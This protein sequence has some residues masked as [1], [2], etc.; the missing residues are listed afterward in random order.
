VLAAEI[1]GGLE[2]EDPQRAAFLS[3]LYSQEDPRVRQAVLRATS[4]VAELTVDRLV[5]RA[6]RSD[7]TGVLAAACDALEE[8]APGWRAAPPPP[9]TP[10]LSVRTPGAPMPAAPPPPVTAPAER[11]VQRA[12]A[13]AL[14]TLQAAD[15]LEALQA[16]ASAVAA[17]G[18][19]G[20]ED[21]LRQ[22]AAHTNPAVRT[23]ARETLSSLS[24]SMTDLPAPAHPVNPLEVDQLRF[25][26]SRIV[27][28][29][30]RGRIEIE[31]LPEEAPT[32]V[33][34]AVS[35]VEAGFYDG[36]VFH[37]VVPGFVVQTGDP[38]GDG[39]GGPGWTQRCEDN[40][41]PYERGTVGM[42]LAGRDTGGSQFFITH[43]AQP[44]LELR[45]T[46]F[47]RVVAGLDVVDA[48]QVGDR[49]LTA[50]VE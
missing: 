17:S 39:Y 14:R 16:W 7:D 46:A 49:I 43:G 21:E 50:R 8:R 13:A 42:A 47:G 35:L 44:H 5:L 24:L 2:A 38:G 41:I 33:A 9:G 40:R 48:I 36:L 22:L 45:Y 11:E 25:G 1:L 28:E 23:R 32:T 10:I 15:D 19:R 12:L 4:T 18:E 26:A 37:R 34:R 29:T 30:D 3:R 27:L 6:L 31:L 20:F